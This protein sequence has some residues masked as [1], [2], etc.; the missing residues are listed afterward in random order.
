MHYYR[1][2]R[3]DNITRIP[4]FY[5]PNIDVVELEENKSKSCGFWKASFGR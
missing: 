2:L 4:R 1:Y 3:K 5:S